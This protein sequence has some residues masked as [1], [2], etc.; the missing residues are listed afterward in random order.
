MWYDNCIGMTFQG[1][2]Y[3]RYFVIPFPIEFMKS[4]SPF[5][6]ILK[7]DCEKVEEKK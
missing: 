1:F 2:E 3:Q 5:M 6:M 7:E 4:F